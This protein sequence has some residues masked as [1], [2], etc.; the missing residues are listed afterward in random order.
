FGTCTGTAPTSF[1]CLGMNG[2][3]ETPFNIYQIFASVVK[4]HGKHSTKIG[5]DIRDYRDGTYSHGASAGSFTYSTNWTRG[6][7]DNSAASPFG[8]DFASFLLGLPTSGTFDINTHSSQRER[9]GAIYVQDDWRVKS[10]L[11][12]NLGLRWEHE[13][14]VQERYMRSSNGFDPTGVNPISAAA[15]AAYAKS[16]IPQVPANQFKALGCLT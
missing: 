13:G 8:Q 10:G 9:Y 2:D 15:A 5:A 7:N 12:I 4:I 16:P 1:Q 11:T 6:P 14:P 3:S